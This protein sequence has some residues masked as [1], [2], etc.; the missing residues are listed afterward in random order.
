[1]SALLLMF[2]SMLMA[3]NVVDQPKWCKEFWDWM[4]SCWSKKQVEKK[5]EVKEEAA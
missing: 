5:E 3:W 2:A 4:S 1:M